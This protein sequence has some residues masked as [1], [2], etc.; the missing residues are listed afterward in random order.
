MLDAMSEYP[1]PNKEECIE[2]I[3]R[4]LNS[5]YKKGCD[6][7]IV[8]YDCAGWSYEEE[9]K[10]GIGSY[11]GWYMFGEKNCV[12]RVERLLELVGTGMDMDGGRLVCGWVSG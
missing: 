7:N 2:G 3:V 6:W 1:A 9:N 4:K 5:K 8:V 11:T 10:R 12:K